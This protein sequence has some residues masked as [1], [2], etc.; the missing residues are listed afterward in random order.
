MVIRTPELLGCIWSDFEIETGIKTREFMAMQST[1]LLGPLTNVHVSFKTNGA[2]SYATHVNE[3]NYR[4]VVGGQVV[5][6][7][8]ALPRTF[9]DKTKVY[10][11]WWDAV[12]GLK[13]QTYH[14]V[15]HVRFSDMKSKDIVDYPK[16]KYRAMLH[17][18]FNIEEDVVLESMVSHV[19]WDAR[20]CFSMAVNNLFVPQAAAYRDG[21]TAADF[22]QYLLLISRCGRSAMGGTNAVYDKYKEIEPMWLDILT[23]VNPTARL[24][25]VVQFGE[26]L[27]AH[28]KEIKWE[29]TPE[30]KEKKSGSSEFPAG[31]SEEGGSKDG[32]GGEGSGG[33]ASS[34]LK[35]E[36]EKRL[37]KKWS[38]DG[39]SPDKGGKEAEGGDSPTKKPSSKGGKDVW[40]DVGSDGTASDDG[41]PGSE[42]QELI[43]QIFDDFLGD[44]GMRHEWRTR[45][46]FEVR[47][48]HLVEKI[49]QCIEK[50]IDPIN[51]VSRFLK[52][53]KGR[54]KP[55]S[56]SG[57]PRG[58]LD[59]RRAMK[60]DIRDTG[61]TKLFRQEVKRG[62][63]TDLAIWLL[64]D[65][66]GSMSG[67]KARLATQ[68][69]LTLAQACDYADVPF[70]SSCFTKTSDSSDGTS[71]TIIQKDFNESF[72]A[73]KPYFAV[74][75]SKLIDG[76]KQIIPCHTFQGNSEEVN[77]W[78]VWQRFKLV[79]HT[80]KILFVMCDG[81]TTGSPEKLK[82]VIHARED[83]GIVVIG[84][85]IMASEVGA[86]YPHHKL[87]HSTKELQEGLATY[88]VE[89]LEA[90]V[91]GN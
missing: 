67:E 71:I 80:T 32:E 38:T 7:V 25:K 68:A 83:D 62:K 84:I 40:E 85:G 16:E 17:T 1:R 74:N 24:K 70:C 76:L 35:E 53:F 44:W 82:K 23:T 29:E 81:G 88:L 15:G 34:R 59:V 43:D 9:D 78:H 19:L 57:F 79:D 31:G 55:K 10:H 4:V 27:I 30:P 2:Q 54:R 49:D 12:K 52:L 51:D 90:F 50:F 13:C 42:P 45:H 56:L 65:N 41:T 20:A 48:P 72:E 3:N 33:S 18:L 75:D 58:K 91:T 61:S 87:F 28:V 89:T 86:L 8:A 77:I 66:S 69:I 47:D 26:W 39:G 46:D 37:S 64:G 22:F 14:E 11:H 60:E 73:T 21:K 6:Q 5:M 36:M 63:D